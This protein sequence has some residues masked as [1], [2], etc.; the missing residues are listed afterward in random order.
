MTADS[1]GRAI[2]RRLLTVTRE[3]LFR[4]YDF[5]KDVFFSDLRWMSSISSDSEELN[6]FSSIFKVWMFF[7]SVSDIS[8]GIRDEAY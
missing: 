7:R 4:I 1:L 6:R 8:N 5:I 3:G 2:S